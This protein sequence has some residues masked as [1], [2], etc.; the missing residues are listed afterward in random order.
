MHLIG[1]T[2]SRLGNLVEIKVT[3]QDPFVGAE[4]FM[5]L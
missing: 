5:Y 1:P 2:I 4:H 3:L